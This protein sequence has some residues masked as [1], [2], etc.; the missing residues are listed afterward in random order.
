MTTIDQSRLTGPARHV[1]LSPHYDDI[2]LSIGGTTRLLAL[3]GRDPE[4][5]LIFGTEPDPSK[6]LTA[7]AEEL[8]TAWGF[9]PREVVSSR[10]AEEA[11]AAKILGARDVFLPFHDA[12]YRG[13]RYTSN[14]VLFAAPKA[15]EAA[16]HEELI[17]TLGLR[18]SPD[19]SVR[20]YAPCAIGCHVYHQHAFLAGVALARKG[21]EVWFYEDLPYALGDGARDTRFA[22]AGVHF[23]PVGAVDVSGVW[24]DKLDAIFAYPSQ[25]ETVF[26]YV[27]HGCTRPEV[28]AV[29]RDYAIASGEG[30][31]GER[32]WRIA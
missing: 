2:A 10:R 19:G 4:I 24:G 1:L 27:G 30:I 17:A 15:D 22:S 3:A 25:L 21:W 23:V 9:G 13:D 20:I 6:P 7:F 14:D 29:M 8:H 31:V 16:L 11:N 5:H 26:G 28:D 18:E 32:F 12:I